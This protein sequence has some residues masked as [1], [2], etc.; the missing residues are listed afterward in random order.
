MS[1]PL[2]VS[3]LEQTSSTQP[4]TW[5]T[6][7]TSTQIS[8]G[9]NW[10]NLEA[11][12]R[13]N[14]NNFWPGWTIS[15]VKWW[16]GACSRVEWEAPARAKQPRRALLVKPLPAE[17]SEATLNKLTLFFPAN[18]WKAFKIMLQQLPIW[19]RRCWYNMDFR[20]NTK[21]RQWK[22]TQREPFI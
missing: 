15:R 20:D 18:F 5:F 3:Q 17:M 22:G 21:L 16:R 14:C 1:Q 13:W 9:A 12:E 19:R 6:G 8:P 4:W 2:A 10:H 11:L 7:R